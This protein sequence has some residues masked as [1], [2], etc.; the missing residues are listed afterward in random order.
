MLL[1]AGLLS[2][3]THGP[4]S[5][6][7]RE[8]CLRGGDRAWIFVSDRTDH[9]ESV[10]WE[11]SVI[12]RHGAPGAT[13][14]GQGLIEVPGRSGILPQDNRNAGWRASQAIGNGRVAGRKFDQTGN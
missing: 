10:G 7:N 1:V 6:K 8:A 14:M 5:S 3:L 12:R 13:S 9:A 4:D 11:T 2:C